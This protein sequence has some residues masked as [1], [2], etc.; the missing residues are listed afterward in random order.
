MSE[1]NTGGHGDKVKRDTGSG[2][3]ENHEFSFPLN[4]NFIRL[5]RFS[6]DFGILVL[7]NKIVIHQDKH[8]HTLAL[9]FL[10]FQTV[11]FVGF[12]I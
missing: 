3:D 1:E 7:H 11:R 6:L 9:A 8:V 2:S 12:F 10:S 4:L 5:S